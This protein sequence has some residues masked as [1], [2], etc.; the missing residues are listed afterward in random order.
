MQLIDGYSNSFA[1]L[2]TIESGPK[3][4]NYLLVGP[5]TEVQGKEN[6]G[7]QVIKSPTNLVG[8][9]ARFAVKHI[10][11]EYERVNR[12]QKNME[13]RAMNV[14]TAKHGIKNH[15]YPEFSTSNERTIPWKVLNMDAS[16]YFPFLDFVLRESPPLPQDG[17]IKK[18]LAT[19]GLGEDELLKWDSLSSSRKQL[20]TKGL[21]CG[22]QIFENYLRQIVGSRSTT[23]WSKPEIT[24]GNFGTDYLR[25]AMVAVYA[26]IVNTSKVTIYLANQIDDSRQRLSGAHSYRIHFAPNS[27]PP[28]RAYWSLSVYDEKSLPVSN[29]L[30]RFS[31]GSLDPNLDNNSDGS[32]DIYFSHREPVKEMKNWLPTP[33]D[34]FSV[35]LRIYWPEEKVIRGDWMPPVIE[36][37]K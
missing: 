21:Q 15:Y 28:G 16:A 11:S 8:L 34:F 31:L 9:F 23:G 32:I 19:L 26:P 37:L 7:Y 27:L 10:P 18:M 30:N 4:A 12:M 36:K 25:R 17:E 20:F 24:D 5:N 29:A 22:K 3:E 14:G 13:L 33:K 2:G 35:T 6:P 1:N